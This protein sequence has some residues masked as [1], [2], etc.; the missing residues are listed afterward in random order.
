LFYTGLFLMRGR[1]PAPAQN[2]T[3]MI[4]AAAFVMATVPFA[5]F[6]IHDVS[7]FFAEAA[8]ILHPFTDKTHFGIL[9]FVHFLALAYLAAHLVPAT[10][11]QDNIVGRLVQR[12][13][14]QSLAV[15]MSGM[16]AA[17]VIALDHT[18]RT[19]ATIAMA[20]VSGFL[21]LAAVALVV[22]WYKA[23][24]WKSTRAAPALSQAYA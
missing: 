13:G 15:F 14:Q 1:L 12:I 16:V 11:M 10:L 19:P 22:G 21:V 5:W 7:P 18:G 4:A 23:T 9:R 8:R 3:L 6:R 20:N 17:Q 2:R 24:P